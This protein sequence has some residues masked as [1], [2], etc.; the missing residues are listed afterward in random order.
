[1]KNLKIYEEY[2]L[3]PEGDIEQEYVKAIISH[4]IDHMLEGGTLQNSFDFYCKVDLDEDLRSIAVNELNWF[5][6]DLKKEANHLIYTDNDY[7]RNSAEKY[8]L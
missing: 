5:I 7:I 2:K 4:Y 6:N 3:D 1:M 8:N